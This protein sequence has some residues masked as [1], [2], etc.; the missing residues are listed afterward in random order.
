[1]SRKDWKS[2]LA[3]LYE[4]MPKDAEADNT[5]EP[6]VEP[7]ESWQPSK[8]TIYIYKDRKKRKGKTVSIVEGI[9]APDDVLSQLAREMKTSCGAGGSVVDGEIII[10]GDFQQKL[11]DILVKKGFKVKLK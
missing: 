4:D 3:K 7:E 8:E 1:M 11:K 6:P 5:Y 9:K 10:Q 2:A